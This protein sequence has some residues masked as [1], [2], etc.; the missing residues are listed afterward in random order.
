MAAGAVH[1]DA[2]RFALVAGLAL[3]VLLVITAPG[4]FV[5]HLACMARWAVS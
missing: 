5:P 1:F 2:W 4:G 3:A